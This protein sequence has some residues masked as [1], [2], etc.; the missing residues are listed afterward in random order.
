MEVIREILDYSLIHYKKIDFKVLHLLIVVV[1]LIVSNLTIKTIQKIVTKKLPT[2]ESQKFIGVFQFF[3]YFVY[4]IVVFISLHASG[5]DM[6][7]FF[8]ASAAILVGIGFAMQQLFQDVLS[9]ILMILD[10]SLH[11]GDIIEIDGRVCKVEKISLRSTKAVTRNNRVLII[12]NHKFINDILFNW[13]QNSSTNREN[14]T[15]SI[16]YGTDVNKVKSILENIPYQIE[17]VVKE[18]NVL[19]LFEDFGASGLQFSLYF[20]V[21]NGMQSPLVQ[22]NIRFKINEEFVKAGIVIPFPQQD[23]YLKT[24]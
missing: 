15:V 18:E 21:F 10:Q 1:S 14:V 7:L 22:S 19:V 6:T 16:A 24:K 23:I 4:V 11:V 3:K 5:V 8:T 17:G 9:G 2:T 12:P 20:H 13:T